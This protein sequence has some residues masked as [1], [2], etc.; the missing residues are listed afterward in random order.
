VT[1]PKRAG[2]RY[3]LRLAAALGAY[4]VALVIVVVL[5][6]VLPDSPWRFAVAVLPM[7]PAV[8]VAVAVLRYLR[9]ADELQRRIQ[10]E[11]LGAAFAMGSL[12]T[13]GYGFLQLAGAPQVSWFAVW[14]VYAVCWLVASALNRRR[15]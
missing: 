15:Y 13:F 5:L 1:S 12:I 14:P 3:H 7:V 9:E 6:R 2:R 10:L 8:F 4:A 11:S